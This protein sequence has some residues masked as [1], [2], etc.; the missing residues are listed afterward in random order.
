MRSDQL[1]LYHDIVGGKR[2]SGPQHFALTRDDGGLNGPFNAFLLV[3]SVGRAL[4]SV[5]S[6]L[7]FDGTLSDRIR[8]LAILQ[9]AAHW[10]SMFERAAHENVGR[11][12]G[13]T[14]G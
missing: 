7:R 4:Q 11:S 12:V 2:A 9:V 5:G 10:D 8:E 6:A 14:E 13:L 3:P 1:E